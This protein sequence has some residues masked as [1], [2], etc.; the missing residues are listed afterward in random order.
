MKYKFALFILTV[1]MLATSCQPT[2]HVPQ[3]EY[4]LNRVK[5]EVDAKD[6]KSQSLHPYLR[7]HPNHKTFGIIG[8]PL[9]FY[10]MSGTKD[11]RW[12]RFMRKIGTPP[13]IYDSTLTEK[14]R[15]EILKA[16]KNKG[17]VEAEV[18]VDTVIKK[19]KIKVTYKVKGNTPYRLNNVTYNIPDD[20][21]AKYSTRKDTTLNVLK[22]GTRFD[23]YILDQERERIASVLNNRGYYSFG[24]EYITFVAD[25][26]VGDHLV[27]LEVN[28]LP[29]PIAKPD[30][31]GIAYVKHRTYTIRDVYFYTDYNPM[32]VD[33]LYNVL[34][35]VHYKGNTIYYGE[36]QY[37]RP[38]VLVNNCFIKSGDKYSQRLVDNT[39]SAYGRLR[40]FKYVNVQFAP[41]EVDG[42]MMLDCYILLTR[43]KTQT[44]STELEGTNS[45]GNFGF[46]VGVAY[47][48]R[49][50]FKGSQT[51]SSKLRAAYENISGD[52]GG[53]ISNNYLEL[54]AEMGVSFP[55]FIF[56]FA[57][58]KQRQKLRPTTELTLSGNF[59][60]R[61]EFVRVIAGAGWAYNWY[62]NRNRFK[63]KLDLVDISYI[64]LPK[65][66]E[67]F[68]NNIN[69]L[70]VAN[71]LLRYSYEDHF[72]MRMAYAIY[73]S[74]I[75]PE[76]IKQNGNI[77]TFRMVNEI[78]GN[79]LYGISN[80]ISRTSRP[81]DGYSIFGIRYAQYYK[82]DMDYTY[83]FLF[84][85]K[86]SL[87][88]HV[89]AGV[90]VPYGNSEMLPFEKRYFSG[91]ANSVRGWSVR[92]LGPGSYQRKDPTSD[93]MNQCGD[94]RMDL[95]VEYRSKL[96]WKLELA[97][98]I[99][100][101]NIWTIKEYDA[102]PG[103]AFKLN[104][105]YKELALAYGLGLRL[106][107]SFFV[108]RLDLGMKAYD[109]SVINKSKWVI[110]YQ[111]FKRD[112]ALHFAVGYPF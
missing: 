26:T 59:Q 86:N 23:Y 62:S 82:C 90:A 83:T 21:I 18:A 28:L 89:G 102:Q 91:G 46:A 53:L 103:G 94:V 52:L 38:S 92:S 39:M 101:G 34:D 47:Q 54:G 15:S 19:R 107:F 75:N 74:N 24:K 67:E 80:A 8:L 29:Y 68:K 106:D 66:T 77:Y 110:S 108:L 72:I 2:K 20:T 35:T 44:I 69:E 50:I 78:A 37:L 63:H 79:L 87:S 73:L 97:A 30:S 105:F 49:N 4:L 84:N 60:R 98:F 57:K 42:E 13:V 56:P 10:N 41:V 76:S 109:P 88:L 43:G 51:F 25:T 27:D 5:I 14:S 9:A 55:K 3:G 85:E 81:E 70:S 71:P 104:K 40:V 93:F 96:I 36:N 58:N 100:A 45:A 22:K 111:N 95:N 48:H 61:P 99:D 17:Y 112:A 7:Q 16:M 33:Q 31:S 1:Y 32:N 12:N 6:I 11:N 64:Y 65:V